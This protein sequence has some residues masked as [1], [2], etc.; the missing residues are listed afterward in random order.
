MAKKTN[1]RSTGN[2]RLIIL[3]VISLAIF[4]VYLNADKLNIFKLEKEDVVPTEKNERKTNKPQAAEKKPSAKSPRGSRTRK[5]AGKE[6]AGEYAFES[7]KDF[8]LPAYTATDQIIRHQGY[9]LC[10]AEKY[11]QASWVAYQLT[12]HETRGKNERENDFRPDP[13]VSTGSALPDDY[14]G[15]GYDRGHLA[16]AADFKF[17]APLMSESFFMSNMSP[18][19][20]DFNRGIWENLESRVR[21]WVKRD[22]VLYI[23]TGPVL[24]GEMSFIGKRN[25]VAVPPMY[26]K[27]VLDL[28]T[29]EVKAIAFLMKNEGS[30]KSLQ[31]FAV[32]I[33][34]VEKETGLDF[35]PLLPDDMEQELE[36]SLNVTPWFTRGKKDEE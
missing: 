20:P 30:N 12:A 25:K 34:E 33:D 32:T 36:A 5:P 4:L 35:F 22:Q 18:Q 16:P 26:F 28:K 19:E 10:Y 2:S 7:N 23:V 31:S 24:K 3:L 9:T 17:S 11:E 1:R 27:V 8:N 29:P 15:S 6:A 13:E 14:R 21:T